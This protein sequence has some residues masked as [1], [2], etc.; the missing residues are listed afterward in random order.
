MDKYERIHSIGKG[1]CG[2][3]ML[4]RNMSTKKMLAMK[5]IE[6][7]EKKKTRT[8]EAVLREANILAELKHPHI[9]SYHDSF[10]DEKEEYLYIVQDYCDGGTLDDKI[11]AAAVT[12]SFFPEKD[13]MHWFIQIAMAVQHMHSKKILHRDLK[14]QNVFLT[15]KGVVKLGDFGISKMM[16][17]TLDMA[18]TCVGTPCYLSP[19]LCQDIPYSSKSDIWAL[20]CLL[21]E[22][23]ALAPAFDAYNLVS[24]FYKIVRG[25][26]ADVPD[27]YSDAFKDLV[28]TILNKSPE[29]RPSASA[30]LNLHFVKEH[31]SEFIEE[32]EYLLQQKIIKDTSLQFSK[33]ASNRPKSSPLNRSLSVEPTPAKEGPRLRRQRPSTAHPDTTNSSS[34]DSSYV[35]SSGDSNDFSVDVLSDVN[36]D[37]EIVEEVLPDVKTSNEGEESDYSDD[38]DEEAV[39]SA[40]DVEEAYK[41]ILSNMD[42]IPEELPEVEDSE[43]SDSAQEDDYDDDFEDY[44][45]GDLDNLLASAK[46]ANE[47]PAG[48]DEIIVDEH[49]DGSSSCRHFIREHCMQALGKNKFEEVKNFCEMEGIDEEGFGP[50]FEHIVGSDHMETCYL[51][52]E[53]LADK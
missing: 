20:G 35:K 10:F 25:E 42:E 23:C 36:K 12:Q 47:L 38:F 19:E 34:C 53:I 27:I 26:Y 21:Y 37:S 9:V 13:I 6:L 31:L 18:M 5:R 39:N 22:M 45:E 40:S 51:L 17:N 33:G 52:S 4:V 15:K 2:E 43:N 3:V 8:K 49:G 30:I 46:E 32:K 50:K 11:K 7:D 44:M 48:S 1:A 24:L 29:E 41:Q 16:D 28:K 14:S